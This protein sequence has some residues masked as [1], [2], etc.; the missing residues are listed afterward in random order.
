M[1]WALGY[2]SMEQD[3]SLTQSISTNWLSTSIKIM[4]YFPTKH[5]YIHILIHLIMEQK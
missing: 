4:P 5:P 2:D 1:V 3:H